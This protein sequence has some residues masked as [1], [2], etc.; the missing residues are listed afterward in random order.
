M[1]TVGKM[2]H[3][4]AAAALLFVRHSLIDPHLDARA[5]SAP[6]ESD[7]LEPMKGSS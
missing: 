3:V 7:K 1:P 2:S 4:I 5:A 6:P